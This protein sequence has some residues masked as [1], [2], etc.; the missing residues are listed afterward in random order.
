MAHGNV[1]PFQG[2]VVTPELMMEYTNHLYALSLKTISAYRV[3]K[4]QQRYCGL[5]LKKNELLI[6][7]A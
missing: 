5:K 2:K 1:T 4:K 7:R 6:T 3:E